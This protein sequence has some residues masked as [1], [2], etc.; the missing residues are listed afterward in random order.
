MKLSGVKSKAQFN[1]LRENSAT[2]LG[3]QKYLTVEEICVKLGCPQNRIK[4]LE[5]LSNYAKKVWEKASFAYLKFT[6]SSILTDSK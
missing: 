6:Y 5:M 3:V 2:S 1:I 4:S